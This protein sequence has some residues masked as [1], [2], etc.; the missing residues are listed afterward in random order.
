MTLENESDART[1][2]TPKALSAKWLQS[3]LH[4]AKALGVRARPRVALSMVF[5]ALMATVCGE[6]LPRKAKGP[7]ESYPNV[8]VIYDAVTMPDG[9]R[10]RSIVTKPRDAKGKMPVIFLAGWLS[11][12][13]VEAPADTKDATALILRGLAQAP[14]F[15]TFKIDKPGC[16]DSE[17]D[18][19]RTDFETELTD[20][21]PHS[22][23]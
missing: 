21:V 18:C 7:R 3:L 10:L 20:I 14:G 11:C 2:R 19:S 6:E 5:V 23:R 9:K 4:L 13:S 1:H 8:D 22:A 17:G 15:C 12:D 16:G